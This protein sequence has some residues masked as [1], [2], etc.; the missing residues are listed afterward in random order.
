MGGADFAKICVF[1]FQKVMFHKSCG[2]RE[3]EE[4]RV[5]AVN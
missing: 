1:I 2:T 4:G 3:L 5:T